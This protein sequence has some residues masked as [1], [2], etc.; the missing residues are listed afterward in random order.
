MVVY[1]SRPLRRVRQV[2]ADL[3]VL[4]GL[5]LAV[6]VGREVA[7]SIERLASIGTRV[8]DEGSAFQRQLS[9][10]AR[11]LA[12][13][14]LA[15]DAVSAPLRRASEH[16][17]AVAAAGAQQHDTAVHLAHLVGGGLTVVFV[18]VLLLVWTRTR[19]RF[20]RAATATREVDRGPDGTE[21]LALRALVGR[22]AVTALGPGVVDRWR[23]RDPATIAAL[24]DLER[25]SCGLRSRPG[26][27]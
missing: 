27:P 18:V 21:V 1:D 8:Q 20:V 4:V 2:V 9:A 22:D 12:D 7:G 16:A 24:A 15:G 5:V 14:P 6:V 17:G 13:I 26:R 19:G 10:T 11:A 3:L 23:E 25:R